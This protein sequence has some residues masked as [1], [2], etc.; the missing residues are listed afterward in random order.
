MYIVIRQGV[1]AD[2]SYRHVVF[3]NKPAINLPTTLYLICLVCPLQFLFIF[4]H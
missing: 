3:I 2:G 4:V 1:I